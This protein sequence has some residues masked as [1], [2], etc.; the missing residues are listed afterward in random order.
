MK[1][2]LE[3]SPGNKKGDVMRILH[4]IAAAAILAFAAAAFPADA[5][6]CG[7]WEGD[8]IRCTFRD[9]KVRFT[10]ERIVDHSFAV[11]FEIWHSVCGKTGR[12][13]HRGTLAL[14]D[15]QPVPLP[16]MEAGKNQCYEIFFNLCLAEN[17]V[18][19]DCFGA[20]EVTPEPP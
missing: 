12:S 5:A 10:V 4:R 3:A 7:K 9:E 19:M 15:S 17:R 11:G 13:T 18:E 6:E 20:I 16:P 1:S 2:T 14:A 8:T